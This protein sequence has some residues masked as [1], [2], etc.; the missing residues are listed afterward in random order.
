MPS[1]YLVNPAPDRETYWSA[2]VVAGSGFPAVAFM[3]DL[4]TATV[5]ALAPPG[6]QI[7]ICD[8]HISAVD[9]D[10]PTDWV[11]ITGKSS[12]RQR[13][14]AIADEF[15]RRGRRVIIGGPY[16]SLSPETLRPHCD[17]LVRGEM[18]EIAGDLFTDLGI[19][20]P[21]AEY[22][23]NRPDLASSPLPRWDLYPNER[24]L[25]GTV[26]TSRGC[27]FECEFCD[28]IQYL[29]RKQR[30]KPIDRV[31]AELDA[32]YACGYREIFLADDN[33]TAYRR[34]CKELLHAIAQWRG[35]RGVSFVTQVSIDAARDEELL[36]LCAA[37]GLNSVFIGV[38]TPN[39]DSL[40][41]AKKRQNVRVD[42]V[43]EV[44]R[45]ID[46]GIAVSGGIIVGFDADG[47]DIFERQRRFLMSTAVPLFSVGSLVAP[48]AT[49]LYERIVR[50]GRLV[51]GGSDVESAWDS[52]IEPRQMSA[53]ELREGVRWLCNEI[54]APTAFGERVMR[55]VRTFGQTAGTTRRQAP[56]GQAPAARPI[57]LHIRRIAK[58]AA[59]R[60]DEESEI[61]S[62]VRYEVARRPATI[63]YVVSM[64]CRY[65]QFRYMFERQGFWDGTPWYG[66]DTIS[67]AAPAATAPVSAR[68]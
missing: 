28:V 6:C 9:Y 8:E 13:M 61:W 44:Q 14:I 60:L 4:A 63:P 26:Q 42:L 43:Q 7:A 39:E 23:G 35:D 32:L 24:A 41:E 21:R 51:H 37:A 59:R 52:N 62:F 57:E 47:R 1:L 29:G 20:R 58:D 38:E 49:P 46:R 66:A 50:E 36:D 67:T 15:R 54:Y 31:L 40:R 55:F 48:E 65:A 2:E 22:V 11:G 18:E 19:G 3:A 33:F 27:P 25:I 64:L 56:I 30:H 12:Q 45:F 68:M 53:A 10:F 17:V 34:H 5:A 16:A